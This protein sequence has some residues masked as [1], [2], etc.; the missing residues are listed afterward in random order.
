[1]ILLTPEMREQLLANG[2]ERDV[3]HIPVVPG[4]RKATV[5]ADGSLLLDGALRSNYL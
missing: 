1:M 3:G 2:R 4:Y 5:A